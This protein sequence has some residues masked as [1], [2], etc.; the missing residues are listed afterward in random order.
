MVATMPST[1]IVLRST[2]ALPPIR[3]RLA[4]AAFV[5]GLVSADWGVVDPT[6]RRFV[7]DRDGHRCLRCGA[8]ERLEMDHIRPYRDGGLTIPRNLQTLCKP[9]NCW[10]GARYANFRR[11]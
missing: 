4:N 9:C 3:V 5:V 2:I 8:S 6:T 11:T 7:L 10:K 1:E